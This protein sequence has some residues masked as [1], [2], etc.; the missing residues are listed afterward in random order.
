MAH[1]TG[2]TGPQGPAG[3]SGVPGTS[4]IDGT[5]GDI[6]PP[7]VTGPP[8][9][10]GPAGPPGPPGAPGI[11]TTENGTEIIANDNWNQ[12]FYQSLNSDKDYGLI[13]VSDAAIESQ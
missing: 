12:C 11:V 7:G 5:P 13:A 8:G 4:G 3:P 10:S 6:G 2:E 1:L 9:D